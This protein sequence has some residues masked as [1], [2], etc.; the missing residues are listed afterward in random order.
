M[1]FHRVNKKCSVDGCGGVHYARGYCQRHYMQWKRTGEIRDG[2]MLPTIKSTAK[3][4]RS[5][6]VA[7]RLKAKGMTYQEIADIFGVSRQRIQQYIAFTDNDKALYRSIFGDKCYF[8]GKNSD[9]NKLEG[10]HTI[11]HRRFP[12]ILLC[13]SCHKKI[14]WLQ[15]QWKKEMPA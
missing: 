7:R 10:H 13:T 6:T 3:R 2:V 14:D 1:G 4:S 9:E 12:V 8:C 15:G 5:R 11:Y